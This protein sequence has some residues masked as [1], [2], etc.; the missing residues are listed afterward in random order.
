MQLFIAKVE[1]PRIEE[2]QAGV[3][4]KRIWG[5]V[6]MMNEILR[7]RDTLTSKK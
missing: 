5:T 2:K 3:L 4:W 1:R 7:R 6:F